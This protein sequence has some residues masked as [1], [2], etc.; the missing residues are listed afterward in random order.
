M[1]GMSVSMQR[2]SD[3]VTAYGHSLEQQILGRGSNLA[4]RDEELWTQVEGL[5]KDGDAQET[6]C[7]G[8]DPLWVMEESLAAAADS[9]TAAGAGRARARGG[10][11]GLAKAFEVLEQAALNLYLG[12]WRDEYKVVKMYS[13]M[14]T[15]FI[16]PVLSMPQ[17]E[18][19]F[20]LLGY[21]PSSSRHEQLCLQSSRVGPASSHELLCLS[22]AFFLAR[23]E[24]CLLLTA[25][26]K[27][28]GE[29]Q[30]ELSV[31][32]ERQRGNS[33]QVALDNTKKTL[34]AKKPLVEACDREV[35]ID[36]YTDEHVNRGQREAVLHD[37]ESPRSLTWLP[38][39]SASP[40]SAK[41]HSNGMTPLSSSFTASSTREHVCISKLDCQLTKVSPL[42]LDTTMSSSGGARQGRHPRGESRPDKADSQSRSLQVE[43]MGVCKSEAEAN[44]LCDCRQISHPCLKS[45]FTC[46]IT[47]DFTCALLQHCYTENH[48]MTYRDSRT[49]EGREFGALSPQGESLRLSDTSVSPTLSSGSAAI[50]PLA[51][52]D[53]P[54]SMMPSLH[55]IAYHKCCDLTQLDPQALCVSCGVFHT[56]S[57]REIDFCQSHHDIKPLGVCSCGKECSRKPLV[58]CRYCGNEYCND[59]WYRN[60]VVCS[61]GQTFDQSSPV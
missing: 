60:P 27:H 1:N 40:P 33:V 12:P 11:Q 17:I 29:A 23:C 49:E 50:S 38:Q 28:V 13:G 43:A 46:N 7:L 37:D 20:G 57:C 15:H 45:C 31:V 41:A 30:W 42:E 6:H 3:L 35:E 39:S 52:C 32:R 4:C 53:D 19:L 24:C 51:L 61:C 25:L 10:L 22:C 8:L 36:L 55:P 59:C 2:A 58:L 14:F 44:N 9:T 26:G 48:L 5:L 18:K 21:E 16:K 56:G 34:D 54:K 47:H